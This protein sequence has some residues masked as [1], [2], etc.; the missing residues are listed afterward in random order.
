MKKRVLN[1]EQ[2]IAEDYRIECELESLVERA[3]N[4]SA[5]TDKLREIY[6]NVLLENFG[7]TRIHRFWND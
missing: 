6:K 1:I 2:F 4:E 3:I 5:N 7:T